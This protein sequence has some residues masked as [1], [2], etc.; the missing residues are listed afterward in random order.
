LEAFL[1]PVNLKMKGLP[2][3]VIGGG[4]I[5]VRKVKKLLLEDAEVTVLAP[6]ISP[7]LMQYF[8][9]KRISWQ[10][11]SYRKG[12]AK[13]Y[14]FVVTACGIRQVVEWVHEES[15][16]QSFLY[17]AADF[18]PLGNCS[19][20]AAFETGGIH[21]AISTDGRSPAMAKYV[22]NWL[23]SRIPPA[24]GVW[25]DKA[26]LLR[27]E[28]RNEIADSRDRERFWHMV[29]DDEIMNLVITGKLDEAE[30]RVRNAVGCFRSES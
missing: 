21:F 1:Y 13:G 7:E 14:R 12:D 15:L 8:R 3:L 26:A 25:L 24:F 9:E 18:P 20:P 10:Q 23:K 30:E 5:A 16:L 27:E 17:N 4:H 6:E 2:C 28:L 11:A 29:F 22:K 19:L